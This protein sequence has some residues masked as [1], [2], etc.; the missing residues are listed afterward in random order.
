MNSNIE[1]SPGYRVQDLVGH[2]SDLELH[3]EQYE[4]FVSAYDAWAES[5]TVMNYAKM[6]TAKN[7]ISFSPVLVTEF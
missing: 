6:M 3:L 7:M 4:R 2:I 1:D 5:P